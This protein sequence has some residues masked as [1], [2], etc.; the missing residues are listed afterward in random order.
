MSR[1]ATKTAPAAG[2]LDKDVAF[3]EGAKDTISS[4]RFSPVTNHMATASWDG[5][6]YVYDAFSATSI[7]GVAS[8]EIQQPVFDCDF[9]KDGAMIAAVG[10]D[11][12][13][14]VY[15]IASGQKK[16]FEGHEKPVRQVRYVNIPSAGAPIIATGSW[17]KTVRYWDLRQPQAIAKIDCGE[18]VY[19]ID[20][21]SALLVIALADMQVKLVNLNGNPTEVSATIKSPLSHQIRSVSASPDGTRWGLGSIEGRAGVRSLHDHDKAINLTWRCHREGPTTTTGRNKEV[22]IYSV[23]QV[24][25][26]PTN[27]NI[28][29]TAGSD[30]SFAFWDVKAHSRVKQFP[31]VGGPVTAIAF[32]RDAS[33]F[34]YAVGYDWSKGYAHNDAT[35]PRKLMLHPVAADETKSSK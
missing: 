1:F 14:H 17:D 8:I 13:V 11:K 25:F 20:T 19:A 2:P 29:A 35:Y 32:N 9:S 24:L 26:H 22:K 23:E 27:N 16:A 28:M 5:N 12:K 4:I 7:Q 21:S 10:A 3:P 15:D 30:G 33:A 34:A 18:R 6:V 31:K